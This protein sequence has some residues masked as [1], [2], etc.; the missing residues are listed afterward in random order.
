MFEL[1][2]SGLDLVDQAGC[3]REKLVNSSKLAILLGYNWVARGVL[4]RAGADVP[5]DST[6]M[7]GNAFDLRSQGSQPTD[8][9]FVDGL[10][11]CNDFLEDPLLWP[12]IEVSVVR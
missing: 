12:N 2:C 7:G 11:E 6:V 8:G 10:R 4:A 5:A 3:T 1:F 9:R